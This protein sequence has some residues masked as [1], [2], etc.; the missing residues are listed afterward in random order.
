MATTESAFTMY[1]PKKS[2]DC[3]PKLSDCTNLTQ[4]LIGSSQ[5]KQSRCLS[6]TGSYFTKNN[7][8]NSI[9]MNKAKENFEKTPIMYLFEAHEIM[10][11]CSSS[12]KSSK[13]E[14]ENQ[15]VR[16]CEDTSFSTIKRFEIVGP[17]NNKVE[18]NLNTIQNEGSISDVVSMNSLCANKPKRFGDRPDVIY[19]TIL[20]SFKKYYLNDFNEVT[21]YKKRKRRIANQAFLIDMTEHY[22]RQKFSDSPFSDLGLFIAALVQPKLPEALDNNER[23]QELSKAV[24][25]VLYRFNKSKMNSLLRYPQ[26]AYMLKNFLSIPDLIEF[27]GEKSSSPQATQNLTAQIEFLSERCN[28]VLNK[29]RVAESSNSLI[30]EVP[31][32]RKMND[33]KAA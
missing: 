5:T 24:C 21:D 29:R 25:E 32:Q 10:T 12:P 26:F 7:L 13:K 31:S 23:L 3:M 9:I 8:V 22:V 11:K 6:D 18:Q 27:I 33:E 14:L 4:P 19:K 28:I 2:I 30:F 20:R 15:S 16:S 17:T 1:A